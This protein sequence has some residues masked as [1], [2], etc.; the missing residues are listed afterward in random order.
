MKLDLPFVGREGVMSELT[1]LVARPGFTVLAGL[2]GMG[3]S[4]VAHELMTTLRVVFTAR[5]KPG[6]VGYAVF[7]N[8]LGQIHDRYPE[9]PLQG[10]GC[11]RGC[12]LLWYEHQEAEGPARPPGPFHDACFRYYEHVGQPLLIVDDA[13][14][15]D[16][17]SVAVFTYLVERGA[18]I[19]VVAR[20]P[21]QWASHAPA[22]M[23]P[24]LDSA[25]VR[26]LLSNPRVGEHIHACCDG[27]PLRIESLLSLRRETAEIS[28][29]LQALS[30]HVGSAT[31]EELCDVATRTAENL[32]ALARH[33]AVFVDTLDGTMRWQIDPAARE[34]ISSSLTESQRLEL[35][36]R[37]ADCLRARGRLWAAV[38]H[39]IGARRWETVVPIALA[40]ADILQAQY[41]WRGAAE[42]MTKVLFHFRD[43]QGVDLT[44]VHERLRTIYSSLGQFE[45]ALE[46]DAALDSS[47]RIDLLTSLGRF[48]VA[49]DELRREQHGDADITNTLRLASLHL[50]MGEI[51][52]SVAML[53]SSLNANLTPDVRAEAL[54]TLGKCELARGRIDAATACFQT[55]LENA[56]GNTTEQ[57]RATTNLAVCLIEKGHIDSARSVLLTAVPN[58]TRADAIV[59]EDLAVCDHLQGQIAEALL[60]YR[61]ALL[62]FRQV[63]HYE[64][65]AR[66]ALNTASLQTEIGDCLGAH[67]LLAEARQWCTTAELHSLWHVRLA[68][69]WYAVGDA[70][71]ARSE[72]NAIDAIDADKPADGCILGVRLALDDGNLL[73]TEA[74]LRFCPDSARAWCLRASLS[75]AKGDTSDALR[76]A[77]TARSM[78]VQ[79][80]D[81][82]EALVTIANLQ[83]D[84][85]DARSARSVVRECYSLEASLTKRVPSELVDGWTQRRMRVALDK[86]NNRLAQVTGRTSSAIVSAPQ[87]TPS[88]QQF[89]RIVGDS[90]LLRD[91]K[92]LM[93]RIS[94]SRTAAPV[95]IRGES[96]TGKELV[97]R[98]LQESSPRAN[99]TFV[100]INC[101]AFT[102]TL[103]MSELFGHA[104]G[105]FTGAVRAQPGCFER[106]HGGTLF[107]DEV[108]ET[109]PRMQ[110]ALLRVLQEGAIRRVGGVAEITV[111]VR[112]LAATHQDL[113]TMIAEGRFRED[114]Y[115]RL[116]A[117]TLFVPPLAART[118]DIPLLCETILSRLADECETP[119]KHLSMDAVTAL[120]RNRWKGNVR[121]LENC[122][123]QALL[124]SD[125]PTIQV[126]DLQ[127]H[128]HEQIDPFDFE[129]LGYAVARAGSL[130]G[131]RASLERECVKRALADSGGNITRA[132]K[133]LGIKRPRL[134]LM[135][136]RLGLKST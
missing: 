126:S 49:V 88:Y 34:E 42:L 112:V 127:L 96:G 76:F 104:R 40:A 106:A 21:P 109:S 1:D 87:Q 30:L 26:T 2:R 97:A 77:Q 37:W 74:L 110:A 50:S 80:Y 108:G 81:T 48:E 111:D 75:R 32:H 68:E 33:P 67:A 4:R 69:R 55:N 62:A 85:A 93:N 70:E 113:E 19:L 14:Y 20:Q 63:G 66:C 43:E 60:R 13:E 72:L 124:F 79:P 44:R 101:S 91:L 135:A 116:S 16:A 11:S 92:Q 54:N 23:L 17:D 100:A 39:A 95:L 31:T 125:R 51:E 89:P 130:D 29:P 5:C 22:L 61:R 123:R 15:A 121:E 99:A 90:P 82:L 83:L 3:K 107:L 136:K 102:D 115:Y 131:M 103:L 46:H 71:R 64:L 9:S 53:E 134:S 114:L 119:R 128:P 56:G 78:S 118:E 41:A 47:M 59:L 52:E 122:L 12:H 98:S 7:A 117:L 73:Q 36:G 45:R 94:S 18:R 57:V 105:A 10:L 86:L 65:L 38:P 133:L 8:L 27:V 120:R 6:D 24:P 35:H 25:A 58:G 84:A 132:A 28:P 129:H